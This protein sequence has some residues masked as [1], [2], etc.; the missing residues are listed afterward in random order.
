MGDGGELLVQLLIMAIFGGISA[1]IASSKGRNTVGWFFIGFFFGCI[2]LIIIL[3]LSNLLEDQARWDAQAVEQ[4]RLR[5]Q[6]RQ[7]QLKNE[8]FR[9]HTAARLDVHDRTLGIDTRESAPALPAAPHASPAFISSAS[10]PTPPDGLPAHNWF[11]NEG[12]SQQGP[13]TFALLHKRARQG[14]LQPDTLVWAEGMKEWQPAKTISNLF[15]S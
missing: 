5:E 6:L 7:E 8:T 12:G 4:R 15:S 9:Q 1:A 14:S 11:T 10:P 2:G 13:Y 3:C